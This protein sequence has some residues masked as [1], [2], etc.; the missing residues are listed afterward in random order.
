M[1]YRTKKMQI[2]YTPIHE[3]TTRF[4]RSNAFARW[5]MGPLGCG[6]S[7]A[8]MWEILIRA[9][10]QPVSKTGKRRSRVIFVRNTRQMMMDSVLPILKE[11]FVEGQ[12][13]TWR[14]SESVYQVR[15]NDIECDILL[16][17]LEDDSDIRRVLSTNATFCVVD[18]WREIPVS[19]IIQLAGRAGR[20]PAKEDE[21]CTFAGIFGAS[22]PPGKDSDWYRALEEQHLDGWE[23]FRFPSALSPDATWRKFLRDGYYENLMQGGTEDYI[24]VMIHGQY[25]RSLSGKPVFPGFDSGFHVAKNTLVP[26]RSDDKPL[27][28]GMDFGLTPACTI[29]QLDMRGRFLTYANLTSDNM[30]ITRFIDTKLQPL[31]SERFAGHPVVIIGDPAG[32]QRSQTDER[33]VFEVIR[34]KGFRVVPAKTNS[35]AARISAVESLLAG[36]VDSGPRHLI[37]PSC[38]ALIAALNGGYRYRMKKSGEMEPVPDKNEFSHIADSHQYACLHVDATF[39]S[40]LRNNGRREIKPAAYAW[41]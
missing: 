23:L 29:N 22:N 26:I 13:G 41:T 8:I 6:K 27:I 15:V 35:I 19:T 11:V 21:G 38:K 25:G 34:S 7:Y 18:E 20:F 28:I 2:N 37:D 5:L 4:H 10:Q 3:T 14:A 32:V 16:R 24:Q 36:Q 1:L 33:S 31:L 9:A 30:G 40:Y 17:P 12:I 39:G